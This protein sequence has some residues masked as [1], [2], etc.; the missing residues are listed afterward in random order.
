MGSSTSEGERQ[1]NRSSREDLNP[2]IA[3]RRYADTKF[4][5]LLQTIVGVPTDI[6]SNRARSEALEE[7][8]R[9]QQ[10]EMGS[11]GGLLAAS[12]RDPTDPFYD[13]NSKVLQTSRQEDKPA[14]S[15]NTDRESFD[16]WVLD[17]LGDKDYSPLNLE[18]RWP[19]LPFGAAFTDLYRITG[20][21]NPTYEELWRWM[22]WPYYS[23]DKH[24]HI[25]MDRD[26][27]DASRWLRRIKEKIQSYSREDLPSD[28]SNSDHEKG[29]ET[30]LDQYESYS[31]AGHSV[32]RLILKAL[33]GQ[34]P[35]QESPEAP[36]ENGQCNVLATLT[37]TE[38]VTDSDGKVHTKVV[39][40]KVFS[41][42]TEE[43]TETIHKSQSPVQRAIQSNDRSEKMTKSE[44][45]NNQLGTAGRGW[46]WSD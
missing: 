27:A 39:L 24:Q 15:Q 32:E 4:S 37:T 43:S 13:L 6:T 1:Q 7:D 44:D 42:G 8:R 11:W 38:Q 14:G 28:N 40:K 20:S 21:S 5:A 23:F 2:F 31:A 16:G 35:S 34:D 29:G 12:E 26:M 33:M 46:F 17:M 18:D 25:D 22:G 45:T 9:R 10:R 3:F 30:E 36:Q 19:E 41:D